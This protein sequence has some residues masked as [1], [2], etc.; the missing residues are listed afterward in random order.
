MRYLLVLLV[1]LALGC[2]VAANVTANLA[3]ASAGDGERGYENS[4]SDAR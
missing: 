4:W 2:G 1:G 3:S